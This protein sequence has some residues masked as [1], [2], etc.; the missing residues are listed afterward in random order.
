MLFGFTRFFALKRRPHHVHR[1]RSATAGNT[2]SDF[3]KPFIKRVKSGMQAFV[4]KVEY[5]A[6][7]HEAKKPVVMVQVTN[8]PIDRAADED[9]E[10][11]QGTHFNRRRV[12]FER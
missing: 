1:W 2:L 7:H 5:A 12:A 9:N 8:N 10:F 6:D 4:L 11:P 3:I